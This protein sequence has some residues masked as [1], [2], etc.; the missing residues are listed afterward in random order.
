MEGGELSVDDTKE[1]ENRDHQLEYLCASMVSD[2]IIHAI[3][4]IRH[5]VER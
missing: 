5:R 4:V 1:E 3:D 2:P